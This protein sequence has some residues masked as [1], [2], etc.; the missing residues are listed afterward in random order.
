MFM[1]DMI[2][3]MHDISVIYNTLYN[4]SSEL[5]SLCMDI[6]KCYIAHAFKITN[7]PVVHLCLDTSMLTRLGECSFE[8][9]STCQ[10]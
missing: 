1:M 3:M 8:H 7:I 4:H 5:I 2:Y 9:V 10:F 6:K